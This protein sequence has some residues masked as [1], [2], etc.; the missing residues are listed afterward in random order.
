MPTP[1]FTIDQLLYLNSV[2]TDPLQK[3]MNE[4]LIL[5]SNSNNHKFLIAKITVPNIIDG[6]GVVQGGGVPSFIDAGINTLGNP[7]PLVWSKVAVGKYKLTSAGAFTGNILPRHILSMARSSSIQII[8]DTPPIVSHPESRYKVTK[9]NNDELLIE[10]TNNGV[11]LD[12][13]DLVPTVIE[14]IMY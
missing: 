2:I 8:P 4:Q 5:L 3:I 11:S 9:I 13:S 14:I 6:N 7:N 1:I 12:F 10:N